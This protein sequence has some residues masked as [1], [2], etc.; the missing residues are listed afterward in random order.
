MSI[1]NKF[2]NFFTREAQTEQSNSINELNEKEHTLMTSGV[3]DR[4]ELKHGVYQITLDG[5]EEAIFKPADEETH[6]TYLNEIKG[7]HYTR[8]RSA[9]LVDQALNLNLVPTTVIRT[10]DGKIGTVQEFIPNATE[11]SSNNLNYPKIQDQLK[12]L[13]IFDLLIFNTDRAKHNCLVNED[14]SK[15]HAIDNGLTFGNLKEVYAFFDYSRASDNSLPEDLIQN[16]EKLLN[17]PEQINKL[18][19]QLSELLPKKSVKGFLE[20][21]KLFGKTII[22]Q[23][24]MPQEVFR[25]YYKL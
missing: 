12:K 9:F 2:E 16:F 24:R 1:T 6:Q 17:N 22:E 23:R 20:R 3:I 15:L 25:K 19:N 18:K 5:G 8:E 11:L 21:L 7:S 13:F 10:I 14:G 4:K